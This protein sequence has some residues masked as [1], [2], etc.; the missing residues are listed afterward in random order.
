[1]LSAHLDVTIDGKDKLHLYEGNNLTLSCDTCSC[2]PET[3]FT[4]TFTPDGRINPE[5]LEQGKTFRKMNVGPEDSGKY[6]CE[7]SNA[8]RIGRTSVSFVVKEATPEPFIVNTTVT[9]TIPP[10]TVTPTIPPPTGPSIP[11]IVGLVTACLLFII[12]VIVFTVVCQKCKART[13]G[14]KHIIAF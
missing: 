5:E 10:P 14:K 6:T 4:W 8:L 9:P 12:I 1:M 3:T 13:E 7:A 2:E 11:L